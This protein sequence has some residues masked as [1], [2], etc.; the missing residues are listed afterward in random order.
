[1]ASPAVQQTPARP[2]PGIW[3]QTPATRPGIPAP[4]FRSPGTPFNR[5]SL[6]PQAASTNSLTPL[7]PQDPPSQSSVRHAESLEPLERAARTINESL[8]IESRFP[9]LD[10]Y[11]SQGYSA[12]Y[13]IQSS[14]TWAPFQKAGVHKIPDEIFEQYNNAQLSTSMGLF[15][16]LRHAWVTIDNALY[17][18]DYTS[19]KPELLGFEGQNHCILAVKLCVP[20]A[21]VFLPNIKHVIVLATTADIFLLG[22]GLDPQAGPAGGLSLF[23]TGMSVSVKGLDISFIAS[24]DK[25]G[26]IFFGG[27]TENEIYELTYQQEDRWFSSRCSKI[28]HTSGAARSLAL[29]FT[30]LAGGHKEHVEQIVVDDSR[31]LL[32][33][34]SS[35]SNIRVFHIKPDGG[36]NLLITKPA[37]EIYA[38]IGHIITQNNSL[39]YQ[40]KIVSISAIPASEASRY[41]L[42]A[43]TATG[44]RI[45]LSA[46]SSGYWST[47]KSV[48]PISMQAQ[49]VKVPPV[50]PTPGTT[51]APQGSEQPGGVHQA[52]KTLTMTRLAARYPPGFFFCFT[53][54]DPNAPTDQLFISAPDAGRLARPAEPGQPSRTSESAMWLSLGSRAE[55]IGLVVPYSPPVSTPVGF[56]NDLAV[57]FDKPIPEV[58]ILT[59][60]GIHILRRR[61]LVDIFAALSRQGGGPEGFQTEINN[62][63][64]A[65]GRTETLATAL[66]VACGQGVELTKDAHAM[67]VN[68]P[69]VL[70][71]ARKTFIEYGGKP[72][73]NQNSITDKS[74]PLIEA[75]RPSPRHQATGLYLSRLLR[76]TWK[77]VIAV[78]VT[79]PTGYSIE[80]AVP[81]RKLRDVQ[82]A[83]SALQRFFKTNKSFIKGLS[84]PDDLSSTSTKDDEI[85]LKGEHRALNSLVKFT[86]DTIEG[87]SFILVLFEEKVA[88]IIPLL[89][90]A[91]RPQMLQLTFEELFTTKKGYD[92]AK[93]LVKAIV[94]RNIAKGSNVETVAEALR[95]KCG[96]FCSAEDVVIF[97]AQEQ[98]KRAAEAGANAEFSRNLLNESLKLFEQVADSLP[99][100]YLESAVKQYTEL[101][102][103]AGAIQLVLK[104]AHERDKANEA[105]SWM[106]DGRPE[107]DARKRKF[108]T[109]SQCYDL[110]HAVIV[111]VDKSAEQ[112]PGF[113]DGR[114]SLAITRRNEAYDVISRSK[115]EAFLTNLYDWYVQQ[116]WYDRLLA[117][118]SAFIVTYLQRKSS[119]DITY[120]DLL[121]KYYGQ[122]GQFTEAAKIQL[123]L[124]RSAFPLTLEKRI[125]YLSRARANAS[126][127]TPG[128]NRK[129]KQQLL[130]EISDL[131]DIATIQD[132]ILQ[133][134]KDDPRLGP[135]RRQE[136]LDQVNGAILD[137]NTLFNNYADNAGY[138]DLCLM[139]YQVAD[140]R[141]SSQ[142]KQTWQ[143]LLQ[144]VHDKTA[145]EDEIQPFEAIAEEVRSLGSKLRTSETTFPVH[146]LLPILEKYSFEHQRNVAPA[147]W[148]VDIFLELEIPY[149]RLFE[150]LETMFFSGDAPFVG[151]NR[152]YIASEIA[153]VV[154]K[155]FHDSMRAG[156]VIFG[157]DTGAARVEETMQALLQQSRAAGLDDETVQ[158]CRVVVE[159]IGQLLG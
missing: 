1:M 94:N 151:S 131:L 23:Q 82:E 3:P 60:T 40:V 158:V 51:A 88:E 95:R 20:R 121:W 147:H 148:V 104:V 122:A 126:T 105:L 39:N 127:Y 22:L 154:G 156:T 13:D 6:V 140:H 50:N 30:S 91:S 90:E 152:K 14:A 128:G 133:R 89:P 18:W 9:D 71:L 149:E 16:E 129:I 67:R 135:E 119:E 12:D 106:A 49:H 17:M 42:V 29:T 69:E 92:L 120:A 142:I 66:A 72:S 93:E 21:G 116:G 103:F 109:R 78:Q 150:V 53:A 123:Q 153:Y 25:T 41:H 33:T 157:S 86:S 32:Y 31:D 111:A 74:V 48:A 100:D 24:S 68:D 145:E 70:E 107:P 44:Y 87:L 110:I 155:W 114:P 115:D 101:Q 34:L 98:L 15:A 62:L 4:S 80:P 65:Y 77:N 76:S 11:L 134:L 56:G 46:T 54:R 159:K 58:A 61:R 7:R 130:Q 43:T 59:N 2:V 113:V 55:D 63:I 83:L 38:N 132:E 139:I 118:E 35:T 112:S 8:A 19:S 36:L 125:E 73:I 141:D 108:D 27:R 136:V 85:A 5:N 79:S 137:I 96:S 28:C 99:D 57:Q 64:R 81:I 117:T 97:K 144:S 10:S 75:V 102:F 143:Q 52:I 84:G 45:Y 146:V 138:Y 47:S 26:R 124:A 37:N